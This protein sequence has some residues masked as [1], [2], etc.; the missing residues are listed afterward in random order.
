[1]IGHLGAMR[2]RRPCCTKSRSG[3]LVNGIGEL[4]ARMKNMPTERNRRRPKPLDFWLNRVDFMTVVPNP[5]M[6][7]RSV[8]SVGRTGL[9]L[10]GV[11]IIAY[12]T[13]L[14][15][16]FV[17]A[18]PGVDQNGY[19]TTGQELVQHGRLYFVPRNP[20][21]FI[22]NMM[23][24]LPNGRVYAK[25][26]PGV[27]ILA[28]L[29]WK[30]G[31]RYAIYAVD[32]LCILCGL[33]AAYLLFRQ[34][35]D[36][37]LAIIGVLLL[38]VNPVILQFADDANSH[39]AAFGFTTV[40]FCLLMIW[41]QR[42]G[43]RW[44][45]AAGLVL[46]C[47]PYMR[48]TEALWCIPLLLAIFIARVKDRRPWPQIGILAAAYA[49]P[50]IILLVINWIS[51]GYPWRTGYWYCGEQTGFSWRYLAAGDQTSNYQGNWVTALG[52]F[53]NYGLFLVFPLVGLGLVKLLLEKRRWGI[54]LAAWI[55]PSAAV[56]LLYYWAPSRLDTVAYLRFF[57]DIMPAMILCALW[58]LQDLFRNAMLAR[59]LAVGFMSALIGA[60]CLTSTAPALEEMHAAKANLFTTARVLR[61]HARPKSVIFAD[62][63]VC[64][65]LG[66]ITAYR[67]YNL[68]I[69]TPHFFQRCLRL[70][71]APG[72]HPLQMGRLREYI[73]LFGRRLAPGREVPLQLAQFHKIELSI[74]RQAE[75]KRQTTYYVLPDG[76]TWPAIPDSPDIK[77]TKLSV[78]QEVFLNPRRFAKR[79]GRRQRGAAQTLAMALY[80]VTITP[81]KLLA[82]EPAMAG[83]RM[84]GAAPR[85]RRPMR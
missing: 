6:P 56:Y 77:V 51:F 22:G 2:A 24:Q 21:Q 62:A 5:E 76:H 81:K 3:Q 40:G 44:A 61:Q 12:G 49:F 17:P 33:V 36:D 52:Q 79:F 58:S 27:G 11:V 10:L 50:I 83:K 8:S 69:F 18:H 37:F 15:V 43:W 84:Y 23:V 64:N 73:K 16:F 57:I 70:S 55:I 60:Y 59:S 78:W 39:G 14:A 25:Y 19:M 34:L 74:I 26:P 9:L 72:P 13:L 7:A 41:L 68:Q 35:V 82:D 38:A 67:L 1:M 32:P 28:A 71:K 85:T 53:E 48:Y 47:C 54:V 46:G 42:G 75:A 66:S 63:N 29:A 20:Y 31:G 65:Y 30:I 80:R 4:P 45:M